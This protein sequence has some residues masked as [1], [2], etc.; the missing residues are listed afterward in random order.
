M[1]FFRRYRRFFTTENEAIAPCTSVKTPDGE[2]KASVVK[3]VIARNQS[4]HLQPIILQ[5][6][7]LYILKP[8]TTTMIL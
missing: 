8:D 4:A 3:I 6:F 1:I 5:G 2:T 7:N